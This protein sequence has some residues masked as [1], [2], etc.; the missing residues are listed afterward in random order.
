MLMLIAADCSYKET[1]C[2]GPVRGPETQRVDRLGLELTEETH[3]VS[4][5]I[6]KFIVFLC[7]AEISSP[8]QKSNG[9]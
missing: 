1:G 4:R 6:V 7:P 2:R 9:S 8:H 5:P 3:G